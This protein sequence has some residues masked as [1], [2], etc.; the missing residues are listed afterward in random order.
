MPII[1]VLVA[2]FL[3]I[4]YLCVPATFLHNPFGPENGVFKVIMTIETGRIFDQVGV[5]DISP[6]AT[7]TDTGNVPGGVVDGT[8]YDLA[9]FYRFFHDSLLWTQKRR[10]VVVT[11]R[12][13]CWFMSV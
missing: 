1:Q 13:G 2:L 11:G 3:A 4:G 6:V 10:P 12:P 9:E 7:I 8:G 5:V